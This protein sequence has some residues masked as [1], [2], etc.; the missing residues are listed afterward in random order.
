MGSLNQIRIDPEK[1]R[2][3]VWVDFEAGISLK[4]APVGNP[5]YE[6][7]LSKLQKPHIRSIR[8]GGT[9]LMTPFIKEAMAKHV[10]LDWSGIT[11]DEGNEIRYSAEKA[12]EFFND[13]SLRVFYQFVR[14]M[15]V[16][17]SNFRLET[18][19]ESAGN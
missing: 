13:P 11:D 10:L 3:G 15:A 14:E 5:D 19:E 17:E 4:I 2:D 1:E 12:L 9:G 8:R 6:A 7:E 18:F 16:D